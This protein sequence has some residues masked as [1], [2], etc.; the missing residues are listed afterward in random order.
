[1][2]RRSLRIQVKATA[3]QKQHTPVLKESSSA[4]TEAGRKRVRESTSEGLE[5]VEHEE[6]GGPPRKKSRKGT[7]KITQP[8]R[9]TSVERFKNARGKLERLA[10]DVP[11]DVVLEIFCHLDP[12]DLLRLARTSKDLRGLLMSKSLEA[13]W[14][15]ARANVKG[16]PPRP[17]DLN[18]PQYA[19]LIYDAYCYVCNHKGRC[20]NVLW[21]FRA[22]VCKN[23]VITVLPLYNDEYLNKQPPEYR[24]SDIL[25]SEVVWVGN[26]SIT[27]A[28]NKWATRYKAEYT[29]E[30]LETPADREQWIRQKQKDLQEIREHSH[31]SHRNFFSFRCVCRK[32][33]QNRLDQRAI[34]LNNLCDHRKTDILARL[35]KLGW[36]EEV[37]HIE[38]R[39]MYRTHE[40]IYFEYARIVNQSRNLTE[41]GWVN[42]KDEL[43]ELL[44]N[45]R[46]ARLEIETVHVIRARYVQLSQAYQRINSKSDFREPLPAIGD[47]LTANV[48]EN[49]IWDTPVE[50]QVDFS[51]KLSEHLPHFIDKWRLAQIQEL[52][53]VV[54]KSKRG[55]TLLVESDLYLATSIFECIQCK[56]AMHYPQMFYHRCCFRNKC[57][58]K[59]SHKRMETFQSH[60]YDFHEYGPWTPRTLVLSD[61]CLPVMQT[62][63][64]SCSLDPTTTTIQELYSANP[65]I[66]CV[67]CS[68][69]QKSLCLWWPIVFSRDHWKHD[70]KINMSKK[71]KKAAKRILRKIDGR[72]DPI[73]C[74]HCHQEVDMSKLQQHLV[75]SHIDTVILDSPTPLHTSDLGDIQEHW[76]FN[77][78]RPIQSLYRQFYSSALSLRVASQ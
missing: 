71:S 45:H 29:Y 28:S 73:C 74:A 18:E 19:R 38:K 27:V 67:T 14:R 37:E 52:L 65:L 32:W 50:E 75:E 41:E 48:F 33:N 10:K 42:I 55:P 20:E 59:I 46:T 31:L 58:S 43:V 6:K 1:M 21:R 36:R 72:N 77:P 66:Q 35:G 44:S 2:S 47:I 76:Y 70:L 3:I 5:L 57:P 40:Q 22:R 26:T 61:H 34:E 17:N 12:G 53:M 60:Y 51:A 13:I 7:S 78:R 30:A 62:I 63:I 49:L 56:K 4:I 54:Q 8:S 24:N 23:C 16:L 11:L 39:G 9:G 69:D 64:K 15:V 68:F 25:P